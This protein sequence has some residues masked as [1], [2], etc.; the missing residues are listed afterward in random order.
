MGPVWLRLLRVAL[1]A[2]L[3]GGCATE[4]FSSETCRQER[5]RSK[6]ISR[7]SFRAALIPG[8]SASQE[9]EVLASYR[10]GVL[11]FETVKREDP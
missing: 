9:V 4:Q 1:L 10:V 8:A 5:Q 7:S 2:H 6:K 11:P 3:L